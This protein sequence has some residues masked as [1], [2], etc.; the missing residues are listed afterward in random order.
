MFIDSIVPQ[1]H[2]DEDLHLGQLYFLLPLSMTRAPL[3][4]RELCL[5][6][7]KAHAVLESS[8]SL[9]RRKDGGPSVAGHQG[10]CRAP[11]QLDTTRLELGQ[12]SRRI[13]L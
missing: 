9:R 6:A 5:L 4:L 1:I 3:S 2:E 13:E 11:I 12:S 7:V 10:R 8:S